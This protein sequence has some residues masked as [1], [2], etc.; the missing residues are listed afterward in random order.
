MIHRQVHRKSLYHDGSQVGG[1]IQ[2][3]RRIHNNREVSL[4]DWIKKSI[5]M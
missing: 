3:R 2:E 5:I 4:I 1:L